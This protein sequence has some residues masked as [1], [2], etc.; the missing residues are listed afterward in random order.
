MTKEKIKLSADKQAYMN[1]NKL[2]QQFKNSVLT[3]EKNLMT[4]KQVQYNSKS[5]IL[6][7]ATQQYVLH[8]LSLQKEIVSNQVSILEKI[9]FSEEK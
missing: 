6:D 5:I 2:M 4:I 7:R 9:T 1:N 8:L 3:L